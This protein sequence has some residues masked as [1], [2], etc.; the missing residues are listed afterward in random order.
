[1]SSNCDKKGS[2][3]WMKGLRRWDTTIT[4]NE[5]N[6]N[7]RLTRGKSMDPKSIQ[8]F[9]AEA[10][11]IIS[12]NTIASNEDQEKSS[13]MQGEDEDVFSMEKYENGKEKKATNDQKSGCCCSM[14]PVVPRSITAQSKYSVC[15]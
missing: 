9:E 7:S 12:Q 2:F 8:A 13:P 6:K 5:S 10:F 4:S 1:M 15:N 11:S 3:F 14:V